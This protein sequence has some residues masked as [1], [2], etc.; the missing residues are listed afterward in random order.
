MSLGEGEGAI[1]LDVR[2]LTVEFGPV[3]AVSGV[4]F[5]VRRGETLG[6]VGE[7]G[8][9]KSSTARAV[10]QLPRPTGGEVRFNG[11]WTRIVN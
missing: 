11:I 2:D 9:G 10:M 6:L 1:L 3:K 7:S 4:S 8:C 5:T